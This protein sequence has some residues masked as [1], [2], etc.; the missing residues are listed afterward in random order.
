MKIQSTIYDDSGTID[1]VSL[2]ETA[3]DFY[4]ICKLIFLEKVLNLSQECRISVGETGA[5]KAQRNRVL[6]RFVH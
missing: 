1:A 5:A 3:F 4:R 2:T 6:Y